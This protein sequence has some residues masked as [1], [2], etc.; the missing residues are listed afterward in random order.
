MVPAEPSRLESVIHQHNVELYR[1]NIEASSSFSKS[2]RSSSLSIKPFQDRDQH[3]HLNVELLRG[4]RS[5]DMTHFI[6][7]SHILPLPSSAYKTV[8]FELSRPFPGN[9]VQRTT[10]YLPQFHP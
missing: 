9:T 2:M 8:G 5:I 10:P 4:A 7:P 3:I 1:E 6:N